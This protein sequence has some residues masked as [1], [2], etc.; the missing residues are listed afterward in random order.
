MKQARE[1][2]RYVSVP[3]DN[4]LA[5]ILPHVRGHQPFDVWRHGV[6]VARVCEFTFIFFSMFDIFT[7]SP[8]I[9]NFSEVVFASGIRTH[10]KM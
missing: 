10:S 3:L 9:L 8:L 2:Q 1:R 5:D 4:C 7:S 6:L